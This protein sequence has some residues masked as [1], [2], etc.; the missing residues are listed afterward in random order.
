MEPHVF[1]VMPFGVKKA[2]SA[3][4]ATKATKSTKGSRTKSAINIDFDD[5][6]DLLISP[7]LKEQIAYR[8]AVTKSQARA[9]RTDIL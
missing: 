3:T 9:I 6:F 4:K 1:V 2:R 5:V 8:F 7:A